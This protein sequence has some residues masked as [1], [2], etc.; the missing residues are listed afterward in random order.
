M[1]NLE[2][3]KYEKKEEIN[4]AK[5]ERL[6]L[7]V[8]NKDVFIYNQDRIRLVSEVEST[9]K[10]QINEIVFD[11]DEF[12]LLSEKTQTYECEL[13][14]SIVS[15]YKEVES[16][17][18]EVE[19]SNINIENGLPD[20]IHTTIDNIR[21]EVEANKKASPE[22]QAIAFAKSQINEVSLSANKA[23]EMQVLFPKWGEDGAEFGKPVKKGFK[24]QD[25]K[26]DIWNLYETI[27]DTTIQ[28]NWKPSELPAIY[29]LVEAEHAGTK[30]DPIPYKRMMLIKKDKYYTQF[31][32]LY[33]GLLD[34]P[35]GYDSDLK[36]LPT[37]VKKV[38]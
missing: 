14:N 3:A 29:A 32:V 24:L 17:E 9:G 4:A 37:I 13:I 34:A 15:K 18:S 28:S 6:H 21:K 22:V 16:A 36:D 1:E 35:N 5:K 27:Q 11:S 30:E 8:D 25:L 38:E 26:D 20:I 31:G 12:C 7:Y 10:I 2:K 23:L 19:V 33:I